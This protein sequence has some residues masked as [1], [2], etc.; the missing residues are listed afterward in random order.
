VALLGGV[1]RIGSFMGP[2]LGGFV[3]D[4]FSLRAPFLLMAILAG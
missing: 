3:A 1:F 2:V 4:K